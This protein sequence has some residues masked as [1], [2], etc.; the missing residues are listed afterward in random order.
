MRES[1][2]RPQE[3]SKISLSDEKEDEDWLLQQYLARLGYKGAEIK[4]IL[5]SKPSFKLMSELQY[6]HGKYIP[7]ENLDQHVHP[8]GDQCKIIDRVWGLTGTDG[9]DR[10]KSPG[11]IIRKYL[12]GRGGFCYEINTTMH[13][14]LTKIGFDARLSSSRV[15]RRG[16]KF[17]PVT[18]ICNL[19]TLGDTIWLVDP[20]FGWLLVPVPLNGEVVYDSTGDQL[21]I[22][23]C[24]IGSGFDLALLRNRTIPATDSF[25]GDKITDQGFTCQHAFRPSDDLSYGNNEFCNGLTDVLTSKDSPFVRCRICSRLTD[26]GR[27]TF[28]KNRI[29]WTEGHVI[30]RKDLRSEEEVRAALL[31]YFGVRLGV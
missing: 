24:N 10:I 14:L 1:K 19:V 29:Q 7:F 26:K 6:R 2:E 15:Y 27:V 3:E 18:H 17:G 22:V 28:V 25:S 20:G 23:K 21:K 16:G 31:E 4:P 5:E 30:V 8:A 13:W 11:K 9:H 12:K